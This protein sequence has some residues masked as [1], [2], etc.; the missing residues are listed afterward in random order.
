MGELPKDF[1]R[2]KQQSLETP[3][4]GV[5]PGPKNEDLPEA[6]D[7]SDLNTEN[8]GFFAKLGSGAK[9]LAGWAY[10]KIKK[11]PLVGKLVGKAQIAFHEHWMNKHQ[12]KAQGLKGRIEDTNAEIGQLDSSHAE[13]SSALEDLKVLNSPSM[14]SLEEK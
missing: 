8:Q 13:I 14:R 3:E 9:E 7:F 1:D 4:T 10:E 11:T 6:P 12:E 2:I 5:R